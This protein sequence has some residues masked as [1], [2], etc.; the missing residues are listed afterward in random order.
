MLTVIDRCGSYHNGHFETN[1]DKQIVVYVHSELFF[2]NIHS[3]DN[4]PFWT[5]QDR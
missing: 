4:Y 2:F 3:F 1:V 5:M